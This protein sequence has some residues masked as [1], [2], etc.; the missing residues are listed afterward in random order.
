MSTSS[1]ITAALGVGSRRPAG[2]RGSEG[3]AGLALPAG[4]WGKKGGKRENPRA[5]GLG[6]GGWRVGLQFPTV[7]INILPSTFLPESRQTVHD[8]FY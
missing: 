5:G 4:C 3:C 7:L 6:G 2:S 8:L 1:A